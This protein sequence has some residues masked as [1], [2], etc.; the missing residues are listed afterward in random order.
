MNADPS[1]G[2]GRVWSSTLAELRDH[3]HLVPVAIEGPPGDY[4]VEGKGLDIW[5]ANGHGGRA[6]VDVPVVAVVHEVGW[7]P[8]QLRGLDDSGNSQPLASRTAAGVACATHVIAPSEASRR[9]VIDRC[10]MPPDRAHSVAYGVNTEVF[11][12][13]TGEGRSLLARHAGTNE[14]PYL[15][16]VGSLQPRKNIYALREAAGALARRGYPQHVLAMV[17]TDPGGHVP[18]EPREAVAAELPGPPDASS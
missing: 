13:A 3:V 5:L 12:P 4:R 11:R 9:Q 17:T 6:D 18:S 1:S 15:L 16:F 8:A 7:T 14:V 2:H 10:E